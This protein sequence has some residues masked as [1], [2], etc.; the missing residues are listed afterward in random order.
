M[1]VWCHTGKEL[2]M[3][4]RMGPDIDDDRV[5][6]YQRPELRTQ[7]LVILIGDR[8]VEMSGPGEALAKRQ[9]RPRFARQCFNTHAPPRPPHMP[10]QD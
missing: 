7:I 5:T 3:L 9:L 2:G 8:L 6:C 10:N 4:T 1:A